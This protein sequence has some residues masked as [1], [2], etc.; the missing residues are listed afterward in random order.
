MA[1]G[2]RGAVVPILGLK[3]GLRETD[4][5]G[6]GPMAALTPRRPSGAVMTQTWVPVDGGLDPRLFG[7]GSNLG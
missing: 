3:R 2:D 6:S 7:G 1:A 5:S 4:R